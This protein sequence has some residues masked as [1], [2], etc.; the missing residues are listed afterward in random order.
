MN[1]T[2]IK[3][4][5]GL[6]YRILIMAMPDTFVTDIDSSLINKILTTDYSIGAYTWKLRKSQLGKIGQCSFDSNHIVG[7]IDKQVNLN[8]HWGW[9]VLVWKKSF[10]KY[11]LPDHLHPG[12][13]LSLALKKEEKIIYEKCSGSYFDCG[14]LDGYKEC[15]MT[16]TEPTHILGL[17]I[18]FAVYTSK[19]EFSEVVSKCLEQIKKVYPHETIVVVNNN[20]PSV[21]WKET[22]IKNKLIIL[23][24]TDKLHRYEIGAYRHALKYYRA[25]T[26]IFLQGSCY[27]NRPLDMSELYCNTSFAKTIS[28]FTGWCMYEHEIFKC[29]SLLTNIPV[30]N[31]F[32]IINGVQYNSFVCNNM[33]VDDLFEYG[34]FDLPSNS[35]TISC[36]FE[37]ILGL[38]IEYITKMPLIGI[39]GVFT[40]FNQ[41]PEN[42]DFNMVKIWFNQT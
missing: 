8:L 12:Y 4:I 40:D 30:L 41:V 3:S 9:G 21:T 34:I 25:D 33:F 5:T 27:I 22:A 32:D 2:L 20:S 38:F 1:E 29:K 19:D 17:L 26:Y 11:L 39:N 15:I 23:D 36:C 28:M 10:E 7:V 37:R 14:T 24:N 18:I 31:N 16:Y 6:D 13:S 42:G 35:K